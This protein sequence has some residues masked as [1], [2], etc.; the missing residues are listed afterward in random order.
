MP[1]KIEETHKL[2][3]ILDGVKMEGLLFNLARE[4][5]PLRSVNL[6]KER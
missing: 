3:Y 2:V 5:N 1:K 4:C 6:A